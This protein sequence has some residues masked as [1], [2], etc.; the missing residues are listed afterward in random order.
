MRILFLHSSS[1]TYG[2]SKIFLQTVAIAQKNGH[3]AIVVLSNK[4]SLEQS[5]NAMGVEVQIVNLGI[6]RRQYFNLTGIINRFQKWRNAL[7]VLNEIIQSHQIDTIYSNT[8]AVLIGGFVARRNGLKHIWHIHEIIEKPAFLHRFLAWRFRATADQLIVVSKAVDQHWQ[9]ALPANKITQIYNGIEPIQVS[10]APDFKTA[11][12]IPANA[13]VI[14]MAARIHYWKGQ[15]YFVE[16]ARALI[17]QNSST[18]QNQ[19]NENPPL[20]FLIAGDP[21]PGYE[22]LLDDLK[23]QLKESNFEG[24]V[25]YLGLVKEMDVFYRSIDLLILPSQQPDPLPTVILEAMQYGIPVVATAQGGALEMVQE[26]ETGIFIPL[27]N[28]VVAAEK[29]HAILPTSIRQTMGAAGKERVATYFSQAA[30][31]K[32]MKAVF[33][34]NHA[35]LKLAIIGSR[36][37]PYVYSGYETLVKA[38]V[39]R[40]PAKGVEITVYCHAHLFPQKPA[41]VNGVRLVYIPTL[42]FKSLAQP[43]HSFFAFWHMVFTKVD[44]ALVLNVSNGPFGM[45]ARLFGKPTMMNVDGLEW[46][47]PKW[48]GFGGVYFKWAAKMATRFM[49]LLITDA[50]AMQAIYLKEFGAKSVVITYGAETSA[51]ADL[52]YLA[53]W[54]LVER[55]YYLIVGRMIPDNN[56]DILIEGFIQSNNTK[57]LVIVGDVP[58][59]DAYAEKIRSYQDPRLVFTGYVRSPETLA[60]L[61]K[62]CYAY[63]HGHEFGGTNPTLLKAMANGCAIAA[64]DTIFSREVLQNEQ[65]GFYFSKSPADCTRWFNWAES[66]FIDIEAKRTIIHQGITEKYTWETVSDLY[67]YHLKSLANKK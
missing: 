44:V 19:L 66:H 11:F 34:K 26:N 6:I 64:L 50:D 54:N 46:L 47:R 42:P 39:E 38:L 63:L 13:L 36:G 9:V 2:A 48:K 32:N 62:Y 30:F 14:G 15:S 57:K 8:A 28:A 43:I 3:T 31:E 33:E 23:A 52:P 61:Y 56:A 27:D 22:Y 4:G 67:L 37:Y 17:Q 35:T 59:Q 1:D 16:I 65:F 10:S 53:D 55:E 25:F 18:S 60:S 40:L 29:I 41:M 24:R 12:N 7:G 5:L 58:Y 20:Y 21:F 51:G 45:I 49:D